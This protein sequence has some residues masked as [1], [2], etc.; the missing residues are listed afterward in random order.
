MGRELFSKANHRVAVW[1]FLSVAE[2][3]PSLDSQSLV[4]TPRSL[5]RA[6][7]VNVESSCN[8]PRLCPQVLS[9]HAS[10]AEEETRELQALAVMPPPPQKPLAT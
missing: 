6:P 7:S 8:L 4:P 5:S 10:A 1:D 3:K 9:Y 2:N